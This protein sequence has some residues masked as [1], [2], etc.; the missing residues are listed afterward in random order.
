MGRRQKYKKAEGKNTQGTFSRN[1]S[2]LRAW[3]I[4]SSGKS[5]YFPTASQ[6]ENLPCVLVLAQVQA[7]IWDNAQA[8]G[9]RIVPVWPLP[10]YQA[11]KTIVKS[12]RGLFQ[13]WTLLMVGGWGVWR[14]ENVGMGAACWRAAY[15]SLL[16]L[17]CVRVAVFS[18]ILTQ[19]VPCRTSEGG[20]KMCWEWWMQSPAELA[21][22][23]FL[24]L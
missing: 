22:C 9:S 18:C 2:T 5:C 13:V 12:R 4:S 11:G 24:S 1:Y 15:T 21:K 17:A 10:G 16:S 3:W 14:R 19:L 6:A 20:M 23:Y 8:I 7:Q